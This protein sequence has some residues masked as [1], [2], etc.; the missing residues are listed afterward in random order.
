MATFVALLRGN[1][2]ELAVLHDYAGKPHQKLEGLMRDKLIRERQ[3]LNYAEFRSGASKAKASKSSPPAPVDTDVEDM[4]S[5]SLY[6]QLF[7]AAFSK[8]L[9]SRTVTEADLPAGNRIIDRLT[10]FL[11]EQ[12]ITLRSDG[13]YNHYRVANHLATHPVLADKID[14]ETLDRFQRLFETINPM[15]ST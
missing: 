2:L 4:L 1:Q 10:R 7:N 14:K 6:L 5:P 9:K 8:E 12:K 3:V 15:F 13:G 11:M